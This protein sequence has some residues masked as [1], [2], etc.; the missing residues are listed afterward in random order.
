MT[1]TYV[2]T[3]SI[4]LLIVGLAIGGGVGYLWTQST[5]TPIMN[6]YSMQISDT[7]NQIDDL[8]SQILESESSISSLTENI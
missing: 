7:E 3:T 6:D 8:T 1:Q 2:S 5:Y 4:I